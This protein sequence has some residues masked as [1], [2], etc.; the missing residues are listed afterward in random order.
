MR[1]PTARPHQFAR[2]VVAAGLSVPVNI[3]ARVVL[4]WV[5]SYE[6]AVALSHVLGM[7]T[8]YTLTRLFVFERSGHTV[9]REFSR[10][11]MVNLLSLAQTWVVSVGLLRLVFPHVGFE[12]EPELV[13]HLIGLGLTAI[14]SFWAHRHFSF[15]SR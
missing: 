11:A 1:E 7:V 6:V 8:A 3:G 15:A 2:F 9:K 13:A 14:T 10:F 12:H 4:S 5:M